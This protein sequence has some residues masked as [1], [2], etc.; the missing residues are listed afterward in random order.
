MAGVHPLVVSVWGTDVLEAPHLTP[1]HRWLTHYALGRADVI[2]AT[3]LQLATAT[4]LH[5]PR[6]QTVVVVPYGVDLDLFKPDQREE[7]ATLVIGAVSRLSPEKG[8]DYLLQ[9]FALLKQRVAQPL[10]LRLA[11]DGPDESKLRNLATR[12]GIEREVEFLGWVE[13]EE[14]PAFLQDLDIFAMPSTWEGFGVAAIEASAM[15][16]PV[17]ATNVY[18]IPDAVLDGRTGVLVPPR[19]AELLATALESLVTDAALS[20]WLGEVGR[21]YVASQY[22]WRKNTAQMDRIYENVLGARKSRMA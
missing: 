10:L 16:L 4:T 18:G 3:G 19:D 6:G 12:L 21:E 5:A 22:D 9:A 15:G 2:T 1:F 14:L 7:R 17:V 13:H 8:L 11:G 20:R